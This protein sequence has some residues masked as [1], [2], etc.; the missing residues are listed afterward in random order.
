MVRFGSLA[1]IQYPITRM[2]AFER[3]ADTKNRFSRSPWLNVRFGSQAAP[4]VNITLTS[5]FPDSGHS[6]TPKSTRTKVRF[7]PKADVEKYENF[8][9]TQPLSDNVT[10]GFWMH[11]FFLNPVLKLL[12]KVSFEY[13]PSVPESYRCGVA[14]EERNEWAPMRFWHKA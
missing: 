12:R 6:G 14:F 7:R 1:V 13:L 8:G 10:V 3:I 9:S 2:S 5:A 4:F 11:Y